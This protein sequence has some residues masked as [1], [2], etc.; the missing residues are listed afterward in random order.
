MG[1]YGG[2]LASHS[3]MLAGGVPIPH[4]LM[5]RGDSV[6]A[7]SLR[8]QFASLGAHLRLH[9]RLGPGLGCNRRPG[10]HVTNVGHRVFPFRRPYPPRMRRA[11]RTRV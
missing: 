4:D 9:G 6:V 1:Y 8:N 3:P 7:A 5:D 10:V 2:S 11:G